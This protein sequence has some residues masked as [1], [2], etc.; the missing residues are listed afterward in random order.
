MSHERE[1]Q[2]A[3]DQMLGRLAKWLKI[4]GYDTTYDANVPLKDFLEQAKRENRIFLTRGRKIPEQFGIQEFFIVR[5][6]RYREQLREVVR[7]FHLDVQSHLFSR[8]TQCNQL[9]VPVEK[10][11]LQGKIQE[12]SFQHFSEFF[13][14]PQCG[15]V[16]WDGTHTENTR[17]RLREIFSQTKRS[18]D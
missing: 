17:R 15:N 1:I 11:S 9:L 3:A 2:F 6:E 7:H 13:Q 5:S 14:C 8:C 18:N 4:L 12:K 16:Y 10:S